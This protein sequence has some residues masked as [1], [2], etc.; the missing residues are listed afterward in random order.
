MI[1]SSV[2]TY[3]FRFLAAIAGFSVLAG[4]VFAI[5]GDEGLTDNLLGPLTFGWKGGVGAH[6]GYVVLMGAVVAAAGLAGI[7]VAFRDGD[8]TAQAQVVRA[9]SLPLTRTPTAIS[10]LPLLI[11]LLV[12]AAI[13]GLT[14]SPGL[15]QASLF[16]MAG[17]GGTW[18]V[19]AWANRATGD[20]EVNDQVYHRVIDP[21]RVPLVSAAVV[22]FIAIGLSRV[23][24]ATGKIASTLVFI[25]V[26]TLI[27]GLALLLAARPRISRDAVNLVVVVLAVALL[28]A[29]IIGVIAGQREFHHIGP[30]A[31]DHAPAA[32]ADASEE[33]AAGAA[34]RTVIGGRAS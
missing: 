17:L 21:L 22:A 26:A 3:G 1:R 12:I 13:V 10:F 25:V 28:V 34:A 27:F 6:V 16:G 11:A 7:L 33:G 23:L 4:F 15:F 19:R 24:L 18:T 9:E 5:D 8:L 32:G 14:S 31:E 2:L 29:A 30:A 20:D